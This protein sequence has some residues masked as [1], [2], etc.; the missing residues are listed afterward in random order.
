MNEAL[1]VAVRTV[2]IGVGATAVMDVW[3]QALKKAGVP[4]Q[5]FAMLGRWIGHWADGQWHHAAIAK[6]AP[7]KGEVWMGWLAHY[8]IGIGFA[9]LM[10]VIFGS[11][12]AAS[13]CLAPA[14]L[15]GVATVAVPL[16]VMQPALG[17]GV[18][19]T[20]TSAPWRN[21]FKSLANHSVFGVG[22]YLAAVAIN[23]MGV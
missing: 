14:L 22:L 20:K 6:A 1:D 4:V 11:A 9:V 12:W 8:A 19:S 3:L 16:L 15:L 10:V 17:A 18:A 7:V 13:P 21:S 23:A 5:N 2:L